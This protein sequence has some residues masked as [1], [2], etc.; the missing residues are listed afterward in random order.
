MWT[1]GSWIVEMIKND[2]HVEI[3]LSTFNGEDHL[4]EFLESIIQQDYGNWSLTIRD[5]GSSDR[6]PEIIQTWQTRL[7]SRLKISD[8]TNKINIGVVKSFSRLLEN[9]SAP[10]VMMADQDDIWLPEKVRLTLE[11]MRQKEQYAPPA[12]PIL[13]HTDL[14][15]VDQELRTLFPSVW[16]YQGLAPGRGRPFPRIIVENT[17]W[18]CTAMLNRP[19]I[20]LVGCIP[21]TTL[22]HDWWVALVAAA[23]GDIVSLSD[24]HILWRRHG[25]NESEVSGIN[26]VSR[27]AI[28]NIKSAHQRL[29]ELFEESRPRVRSFLERFREQLRASDIAA[30]EAFL[31]LPQHTPI[32]RRL[33]IFRHGLFFGARLRNLG[34]LALL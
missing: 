32:E 3:I 5:D 9:S 31:D 15:M 16:K 12:R 2:D 4:D 24:S 21:V 29:A 30:A 19:L 17:V 25:H 20:E 13:V 14:T 8:D 34:L 7:M 1:V 27:H 10:Y 11:A 26:A 28:S 18:G 33:D 22:H 6:T 23:F